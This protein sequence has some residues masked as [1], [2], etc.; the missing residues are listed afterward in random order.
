MVLIAVG[1]L[2]ASLHTEEGAALLK[3]LVERGSGCFTSLPKECMPVPQA[4]P[5]F[6]SFCGFVLSM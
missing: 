2:G 4:Q 1:F 3:V 6:S 5:V